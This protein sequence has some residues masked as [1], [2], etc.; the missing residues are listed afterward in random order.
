ML[1]SGCREIQGSGGTAPSFMSSR[2]EPAQGNSRQAVGT[3]QYSWMR[4]A[5]RTVGLQIAEQEG[6]AINISLLHVG[7]RQTKHSCHE[8]KTLSTLTVTQGHVKQQLH[9]ANI[10]NSAVWVTCISK[11]KKKNSEH[12]T[13]TFSETWKPAEAPENEQAG[14]T[15]A[16]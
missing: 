5:N 7:G 9:M 3:T 10:K 11:L 14:V 12:L 6:K 13:L 15:P 1:I 8:G 4:G 2:G 16:F